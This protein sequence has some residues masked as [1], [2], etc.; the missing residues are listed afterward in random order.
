MKS[1]VSSL[2]NNVTDAFEVDCFFRITFQVIVT[3]WPPTRSAEGDFVY[4]LWVLVCFFYYWKTWNY[5]CYSTK[6][7]FVTSLLSKF[8]VHC[9]SSELCMCMKCQWYCLKHPV[10]FWCFLCCDNLRRCIGI[11]PEKGS[12]ANHQRVLSRRTGKLVRKKEDIVSPPVASLIKNLMD[13]ER[14]YM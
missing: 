1:K 13:F 2:A 5:Q 11:N 9:N 7:T 10:F 12:K 8:C 3:W 4:S 6:L 14:G